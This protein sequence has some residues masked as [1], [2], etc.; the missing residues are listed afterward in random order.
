[1]WT[2]EVPGRRSP[3]RKRCPE[4]LDFIQR[5]KIGCEW[6]TLGKCTE[7]TEQEKT[8]IRIHDIYSWYIIHDI[9]DMKVRVIKIM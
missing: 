7:V 8:W 6:N 9:R 3:G 1:M 5:R 2:E 4:G